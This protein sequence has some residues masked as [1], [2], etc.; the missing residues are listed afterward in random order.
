[1]SGGAAPARPC[2]VY[3]H[4]PFCAHRC[5]YCD[6]AV[7][8]APPPEGDRYRRALLAELSLRAG[9]FEGLRAASLYVGGGTP[10]LWDPAE[11]AALV[12][13]LRARLGLPAD[14]EVTIEA[15]PESVDRDRI[16][17]WRD[18]GVN[19]VSVGV[20]SFDPDVLAKLGRRHG[21][22]AAARAVAL[23]AEGIGNVSVDLIYGARRSTPATARADA[24]RAAALGA[25]H[26]SAYAL[27]LDPEALAE[28]VPFARL[29]RSGKLAF[30]G[31][32]E[33]LDQARAVRGAL[34]AAGLRRYEISNFALPG[35]ES[36]HNGLYWAGESYL[37]LGAGAVG[38]RRRE[39]G[40]RREANH[41]DFRR[42]L[43]DVEAGRRPTGEVDEFD[44]AAQ[45]N[46]RLM[47]ALR[48]R[49]GIP[50]AALAEGSRREVPALLR[51][52]LA[53]RR[54]ERLVLTSRGME[55]H[56]AVAARLVA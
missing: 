51:A 4:F 17:A 34:R 30:P 43:A 3:V 1:V 44:A 40:G 36:I 56:T 23:A 37:G 55:L 22:D 27:T 41:R 24:A 11:V 42:W 25:A 16:A 10:S 33:A 2:G 7:T 48:T 50:L 39:G 6:F 19:R 54:G 35:R 14:A 13:E 21:A 53:V 46:E 47:L 28:E 18:A 52:R 32:D 15:N 29:A 20:Q 45:A 5:P 49:A 38:C 8:T 12:G 26:V 9:D 31:D